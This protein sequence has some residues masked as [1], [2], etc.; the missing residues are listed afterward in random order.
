AQLGTLLAERAGPV[1]AAPHLAP[2]THAVA[3]EVRALSHQFL[4]MSTPLPVL[5]D[6]TFSAAPGAFVALLGPSGCGK[7]TLLRLAAGLERPTGGTIRVAG[8]EVAGPDPS[9]ALVFQDPTLYPWR[10]V[11]RNVALGLEARG[12]LRKDD[13][14]VDEVL[15]RVGLAP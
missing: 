9:R 14:R 3:I 15:D 6:L 13:R 5:E 12:L 8:R 1:V 4:I 7:S 11:W 10:S 2:G